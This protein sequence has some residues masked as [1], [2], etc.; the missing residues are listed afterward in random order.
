MTYLKAVVF[1]VPAVSIWIFSATFLF[2][3]LYEIWR[4][5]GFDSAAAHRILASSNLILGNG[6]LIGLMLLL[7]VALFEW[8]SALWQRYRRVILGTG[9]FLLNS[10]VLLLITI[11]FTTAM[12]AAP[13]LAQLK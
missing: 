2:P 5:T 7:I 11:M 10:A 1:L 12:M 4:M 6:A 3:K 13:A 9:V 8:R